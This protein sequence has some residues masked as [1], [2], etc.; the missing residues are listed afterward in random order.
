MTQTHSVD[1]R[2]EDLLSERLQLDEAVRMLGLTGMGGIGKTTLATAL[3]TCLLPHFPTAHCFLADIRS[4][5]SVSG[6]QSMQHRL[7]RDVC[8]WKDAPLPQSIQDGIDFLSQR[9]GDHKVLLVLDDVA[10]GPGALQALLHPDKL[11]A[12]SRVIIT[13]REKHLLKSVQSH[14]PIH[15]EDVELLDSTSAQQ[16]FDWHAFPAEVVAADLRGLRSDTVEACAGLALTLKVL[17]SFLE[18]KSAAVWTETLQK[19]RQAKDLPV[20]DND[21]MKMLNKAGSTL[22]NLAGF[23]ATACQELPARVFS[24]SSLRILVLDDSMADFTGLAELEE[25][26]YLSWPHYPLSELP[27]IVAGST[28]LAVLDVEGSCLSSLPDKLPKL[29]QEQDLGVQ[30]CDSSAVQHQPQYNQYA[31]RQVQA[32]AT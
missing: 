8:G 19:L 30:G 3:Y 4:Q 16:L 21:K 6:L 20:D 17:G 29:L 22:P 23:H 26:R 15:V 10:T 31:A 2:I 12:G 32:A 13:S 27:C 5:A 11:A 25:L 9:L 18:G 14:A 7:L 1:S 28:R 24:G